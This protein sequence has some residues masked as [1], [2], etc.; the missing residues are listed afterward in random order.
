MNGNVILS[1][2]RDQDQQLRKIRTLIPWLSKKKTTNL[3]DGV[4][5]VVLRVILR[6]YGK[7]A[8]LDHTPLVAKSV[9][10]TQIEIPLGIIPRNPPKA[11]GMKS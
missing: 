1:N 8:S 7:E 11:V 9:L 6:R 10:R 5:R 4:L 2:T 3:F